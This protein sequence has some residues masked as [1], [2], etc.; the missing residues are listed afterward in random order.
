MK[1]HQV[2]TVA[3]LAVVFTVSALADNSRVKT[4]GEPAMFGGLGALPFLTDA[5]T[6]SISAENPTGEKGKG[7]M[8]VP[9]P[10]EEKPAAA[11][12][13]ADDLGQGWK[14][15]PF[16][17]VNAG[18][19]ATLMDVDGSGVVQHIW[20]AGA[21]ANWKRSYVLRFYW[22]GEETPSIEVPVPDFFAVGHEKFAPVNSL[23]VVNNPANG[24]NCYWPMPFRNHAK[25]T[26]SNDDSADLML[27]AYQITYAETSVP[28]NAAYL[29]A[30]WRRAKTDTVNPCVILDGVK[31]KGRYV[32]TFLAWTQFEKG[33]FGEGEIKFYMDG[34]TEF[35]TI[36]GTGTEDYFCGSYGFPEPY[37]TAYV[38]T[39]LPT[40]DGDE[41]PN[42]W[43]LYRWH[44]QDPICYDQDLRVTIQALGWGKDGKYKKL[45]DDIASVAYWYQAEPH[46]PFPAMPGVAERAPVKK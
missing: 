29:H 8:A 25:V 19:T 6:R 46:A 33:W 41:P 17:R 35:P 2:V 20:I 43:S 38:G 32:G 3:M 28:D 5:R 26:I 21:D 15:R 4:M 34:D 45:S 37:T 39:T 10:S 40:K 11:A 23:A 1:R 9:N 36:C 22:D 12:R 14:V 16:I 27:V 42:H 30:Q 44:I 18:E 31:G 24:L 7:G 13:A